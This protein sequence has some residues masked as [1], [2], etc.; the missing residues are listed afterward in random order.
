MKKI[1]FCLLILV[2]VVSCSKET[3]F[4]EV[5]INNTYSMLVPEYLS[6]AAKVKE[7]ASFQYQNEEK[8]VYALVIEETKESLLNYGLEYD[9]ATYFTNIVSTPFTE[10]IKD[11]KV[12]IPGKQKI[13]GLDALI[14]EITG[15][16]NNTDI[17]YK[18]A[19]VET[20]KAF[21]QVLTWSR[22]DQ[23]VNYEKDMMKM[24]E[25]FKML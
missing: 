19:V 17:F 1:T 25:S 13:N 23:K 15:N 24:I 5:K 14:A 20:P 10:K 18:M 11:G 3:I 4:N 9:L 16:I 21:Y 22:A 8:E 6:A 7:Q 2:T 12:S